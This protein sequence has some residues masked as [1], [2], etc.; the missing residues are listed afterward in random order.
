M[1]TYG[2]RNRDQ[3]H[4]SGEKR[5]APLRDCVQDAMAHYFR[6]LGNHPTNDLYQMVIAEVEPPLL[7]SVMDYTEGNQTRAANLL[8]ISRSTLRKKLALY[9]LTGG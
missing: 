4:V 9:D 7:R 2:N 3:F 8:G 1:N 6:Q 5:T